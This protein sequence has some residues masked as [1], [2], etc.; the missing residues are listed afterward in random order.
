MTNNKKMIDTKKGN[1]TKDTGQKSIKNSG[2]S[3][4]VT[5]TS[6]PMPETK[7]PASEQSTSKK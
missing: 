1:V 5:D 2:R 4:P 6:T 3:L 7:P